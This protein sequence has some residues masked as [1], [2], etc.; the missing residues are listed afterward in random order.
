[1]TVRIIRA[2]DVKGESRLRRSEE[3]AP[4]LKMFHVEHCNN[5][6]RFVGSELRLADESGEIGAQAYSVGKE[7]P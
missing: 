4:D 5:W 6:L 3:E 7:R 2:R 1:M